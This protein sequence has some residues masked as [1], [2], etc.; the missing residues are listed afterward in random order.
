MLSAGNGTMTAKD[1]KA[2]AVELKQ[3][4]RTI[5]DLTNTR[6]SSGEYI[7]AGTKGDKPALVKTTKMDVA[8]KPVKDAKGKEVKEWKYVGSD[9]PRALQIS[10]SQLAKFGIT[11]KDVP[12]FLNK[13]EGF[14][15]TLENIKLPADQDK[16]K[17]S[18]QDTLA[19]TKSMS[20]SVNKGITS[21]GA[22]LNTLKAAKQ[23]NQ[24]LQ[25]GNKNMRSSLEDLDVAEAV[26]RLSIEKTILQAT[27]KSYAQASRLSLFN[28]L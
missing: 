28:I 14:V 22:E 7:H 6:S 10:D 5:T 19:S 3:V 13:M 18:I 23:T 8:G 15:K 11:A 25:L 27:Q 20:A 9:Q 24:T 1:L 17:Q 16:L 4:T 12:A 21:V 2:I 26:T